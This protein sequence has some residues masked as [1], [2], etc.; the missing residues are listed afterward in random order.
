MTNTYIHIHTHTFS[1]YVKPCL[2]YFAPP[3]NK[4]TQVPTFTWLWMAEGFVVKHRAFSSLT[5]ARKDN[6]HNILQKVR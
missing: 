5:I 1:N 2:L 4:K 6:K 3:E